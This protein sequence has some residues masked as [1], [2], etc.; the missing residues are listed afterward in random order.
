M[1]RVTSLLNIHPLYWMTGSYNDSYDHQ[2]VK[3]EILESQLGS[4]P[5]KNGLNDGPGMNISPKIITS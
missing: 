1:L 4:Q 5:L 3:C 2:E